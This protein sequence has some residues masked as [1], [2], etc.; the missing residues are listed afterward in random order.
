MKDLNQTQLQQV[1]GHNRKA[2]IDAAVRWRTGCAQ[3]SANW[4]VVIRATPIRLFCRSRQLQRYAN[5]PARDS[6]I[7][8]DISNKARRRIKNE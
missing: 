6:R 7:T 1:S 2:T 4:I 3:R 5:R 8:Q